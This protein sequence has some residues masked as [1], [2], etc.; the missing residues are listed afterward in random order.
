MNFPPHLPPPAC[1]VPTHRKLRSL[2]QVIFVVF[3]S[4]LAGITATLV[5]L[6]WVIPT[7]G[8]IDSYMRIQNA[9]KRQADTILDPAFEQK[10]RQRLLRI[11]DSKTKVRGLYYSDDSF[12]APA[13]LLSSDGWAAVHTDELKMPPLSQW[14]A[15]DSQGIPHAA[16]R[17]VAGDKVTYV[18]FVGEGFRIMPYAAWDRIEQGASLWEIHDGMWRTVTIDREIKNPSDSVYPFMQTTAWRFLPSAGE[19]SILIT[20]E[21]DFAGFGKEGSLIHPSWKAEYELRSILETGTI[22][23]R[24]F[25]WKGFFVNQAQDGRAVRDVSGFYLESAPKM[26]GNSAQTGDVVIEINGVPVHPLTLPQTVLAAPDVVL[27]RVLR[28]GKEIIV[29]ARKEA[30]T[31]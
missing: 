5:T 14:E 25:P 13:V 9:A 26:S 1:T 29:E 27:T 22:A 2:W 12:L 19:K 15:I 10:T 4:G 18:R 31:N 23:Y 21:G 8:P 17:A 6:A 11:Y 20:A 24:T 30:F 16:V 28:Q 7:V 3:I